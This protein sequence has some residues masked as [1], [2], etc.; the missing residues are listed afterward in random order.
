MTDDRD[1]QRR[2]APHEWIPEEP[3]DFDM[4]DRPLPTYEDEDE[5]GDGTDPPDDESTIR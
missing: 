2:Y 1:D 3:F 4:L 5:L